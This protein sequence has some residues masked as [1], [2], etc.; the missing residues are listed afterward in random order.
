VQ[1]CIKCLQALSSD[2][3]T[4]RLVGIFLYHNFSSQSRHAGVCPSLYR[5]HVANCLQ[6]TLEE[7][8]RLQVTSSTTHPSL[9]ASVTLPAPCCQFITPD[10]HT[11]ETVVAC[12][13]LGVLAPH[14]SSPSLN[15]SSLLDSAQKAPKLVL[16]DEEDDPHDF[17]LASLATAAAHDP[18][19]GDR[20]HESEE[21]GG[22]AAGRHQHQ[23]QHEQDQL[24][25]RRRSRRHHRGAGAGGSDHEDDLLSLSVTSSPPV[26]HLDESSQP[27]PSPLTLQ[28]LSGDRE[29]QRQGEGEDGKV[30]STTVLMAAFNDILEAAAGVEAES[31]AEMKE[32]EDL[33]IGGAGAGAIPT[34]KDKKKAKSSSVSSLLLIS[35][36]HSSLQLLLRNLEDDRQQAL[37]LCISV[38]CQREGGSEEVAWRWGD[39]HPPERIQF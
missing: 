13:Y 38:H 14:D 8:Y 6:N 10:L 34:A 21:E 15:K 2:D 31:V 19:L 27:P 16:D 32:Q 37:L 1:Q 33:S 30:N 26:F 28:Q 11:S 12:Q 22:P 17:L 3:I 35:S 20:D 18:R 24:H 9:L 5:E 29:G 39:R 7:V 4:H 36:S 25:P 23:Q